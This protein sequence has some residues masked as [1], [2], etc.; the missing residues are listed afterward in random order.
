MHIKYIMHV[1]QIWLNP[2]HPNISIN[3]LG[4]YCSLYII[5]RCC[6]LFSYWEQQSFLY[7]HNLNFWFHSSNVRRNY[8]PITITE[9][10][11]RVLWE[12][13]K[14]WRIR[15]LLNSC[16]KLRTFSLIHNRP[17]NSHFVQET[18]SLTFSFFQTSVISIFLYFILW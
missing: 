15:I 1:V 7:S 5:L 3:I 11:K 18:A 13:P 17:L 2:L 10:D 12:I 6:H 9:L 16:K 8:M 4:P 14:R